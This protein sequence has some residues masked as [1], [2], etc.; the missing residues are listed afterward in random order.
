MKA[1][2]LKS[3][4]DA[5]RL[6]QKT[7]DKYLAYYGLNVRSERHRQGLK[8]HELTTIKALLRE[9]DKVSS[10]E[11]SLLLE[12]FF[13][14]YQIP[15][16]GKECD[17]LRFGTIDGRK[18]LINIELKSSSSEEK[19][20]E[21]LL[22]NKYYLTFLNY[23]LHLF[24][25]N[26]ETNSLYKLE[27][28][29][30]RKAEGFEELREL[31]LLHRSEII[32]DI[33]AL[34][35]P[36][37]YLVSPFNATDKFLAGEYLLTSHQRDIKERHI[38]PRVLEK[39]EQFMA[40]SGGAGTGKTLLAYDIARTLKALGKHVLIVHC[41][42]LNAG[43]IILISKGW[44]LITSKDL[45]HS[46]LEQYD[47]LII[48]EAQRLA[49]EEFTW[50]REELKEQK[51]CQCL[52]SYD[53]LQWLKAEERNT[54]VIR[55]IEILATY[56]A[57]LTDRIR[58]NPEIASFI[59][60]LLNNRE[61][62]ISPLPYP[63]IKLH[64]VSNAKEARLLLLKL[65]GQNWKV[66][67]YMPS[68]QSPFSYE[69]YALEEEQD[70]AHTIIGQEYDKVVAVLDESF[71]Y[72]EPGTLTVKTKQDNDNYY[73]Q[74]RMLYQILTRVRKELALVVINNSKVLDRCLSILLQ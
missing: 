63:N 48:D 32:K 25:Y 51:Q 57:G 21:Q 16:I 14:G 43:Q 24:S 65:K 7:Y 4:I 62:K 13:V 61:T 49:R 53:S 73:D 54:A 3:L 41:A 9:L 58:T 11:L 23:E 36:A 10:D 28:T 26:Q 67:N 1:I 8:P 42:T 71:Y 29:K 19:I 47:V 74:E 6:G 20:L 66:A 69:T 38:I 35:D 64:Y 40:V 55:D 50:L 59:K 44:E 52:F 72:N 31:L 30:L 33:D 70:N 2:N 45:I 17:L 27:G 56:R 5:E 37:N 39:T 15:Q 46:Q 60:R 18:A 68:E 34:F 22:K 12:D